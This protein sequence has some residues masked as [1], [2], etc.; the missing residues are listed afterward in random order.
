MAPK[1]VWFRFFAADWLLD[2]D[3]RAMTDAQRSVYID[4]LCLQS[5]EESLPI[6]PTNLRQMC[7]VHSNKWKG[8][9]TPQLSDKFPI[10][11]D[12]KR[13]NPKL[14][15]A[16]SGYQRMSAGGKKGGEK[17]KPHYKGGSK[18][19]GG[20]ERREKRDLEPETQRQVQDQDLQQDQDPKALQGGRAKRAIA[21][22]EIP[23]TADTPF[24]MPPEVKPRPPTGSPAGTPRKRK[25]SAA[26]EK[27]GFLI[28]WAKDGLELKVYDPEVAIA[29]FEKF[30]QEKRVEVRDMPELL[31]RAQSNFTGHAARNGFLGKRNPEALTVS[32]ISWVE[33]DIIKSATNG[34]YRQSNTEQAFDVL[35]DYFDDD[36]GKDG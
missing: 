31:D 6:S 28:A 11:V 35:R 10:C 15:K 34:K 4:L 7:H 20:E 25:K 23:G 26:H 24:E 33:N 29:R 2:P 3:V 21:S 27:F 30:A 14:V 1:P 36:G 16:L 32:F 9:W 13:R 5:L 12:G 8:I 19:H 18:P 17:S 22:P